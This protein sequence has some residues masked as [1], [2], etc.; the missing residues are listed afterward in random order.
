MCALEQPFLRPDPAV[1]PNGTVHL[2]F[3]LAGRT[4]FSLPLKGEA[5]RAR[6]TAEPSALDPPSSVM[7]VREGVLFCAAQPI[8]SAVPRLSYGESVFRYVSTQYPR[9][10]IDLRRDVPQCYERRGA[11]TRKTL[12]RALRKFED[13]N[14]GSPYFREYRTPDEL[15][16]FHTLA[17][18]IAQHT[19]QRRLGE[20]FPDTEEFREELLALAAK[21]EIRAYILFLQ[22]QPVAFDLCRVFGENLTGDMCGYDD[23]FAKL[24]PG[25]VLRYHVLRHLAAEGQF[26]LLDLGPGEAHYKESIATSS[27]LCA[28][29]YYFPR[30][31]RFLAIVWA[32]VTFHWV[33]GIVASALDA[34]RLRGKMKKVFRSFGK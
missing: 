18:A 9:Y 22:G 27:V 16:T 17:R 26:S 15:H 31:T 28:N 6:F 8:A 32:H 1:V 2:K 5:H 13:E 11:S 12:R 4:L 34:M 3:R 23:R 29:V 19:Y 24:S 33:T 30:R 21:G 10:Y 7:V 14:Q 25:A 20:G